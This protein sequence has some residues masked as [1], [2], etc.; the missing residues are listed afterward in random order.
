MNKSKAS[1]RGLVL[2]AALTLAGSL[3]LPLAAAARTPQV[4]VDPFYL[5]LLQDGEQY[6]RA[7]RFG[8]AAK[9]L[10]V[11]TFG[12]AQ[13]PKLL[14]KTLGYLSLAY[15][16]LKDDAKAKES[17]VRLIDLVGLS[18]MD[19]LGLDEQDRTYLSQIAAF[20]KLDRPAGQAPVPRTETLTGARPG[21]PGAAQGKAPAKSP[22]TMS[23]IQELEAQV[24]ARPNNPQAYLDLYAYRLEQKD[25]KGARKAL[26]GLSDKVPA[27]PRGPFLLGKLYYGQKDFKAAA[28]SLERA[29]ALLKTS[30]GSDKDQAE[31]RCY[32]IL[33]YNGLKKRPQVEKAC[34][35]FLARFTRESV[36][37][38]GLSDRDKSLVQSLLDAVKPAG[39]AAS[40]AM[41]PSAPVPSPP[42][43]AAPSAA[44]YQKEIKTHPKDVSLYYGL[45]DLHRQKKD[46]PAAKQALESLI[47]ANPSEVKA[48]LE[49]GRLRYRDKEYGKAVSVLTRVFNPPLNIGLPEDAR[50]EAAFYLALSQFQ[51]KSRASAIETYSVN[52]QSL[53]AF[54]A[55]HPDLAEAESLA[56]QTLSREAETAGQVYVLGLQVDKSGPSLEVKIG[57]SGPA[58]Y[59]T[60]VVPKEH[61]VVIEIFHVAAV[62]APERTEVNSQGIKAVRCFLYQPDSARVVLEW[63]SQIPSHRIQRT[64]SGLSIVVEK[65][66]P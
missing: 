16:N 13:D 14:G 4:Q 32:L 19:S 47:K 48:Y 35:E 28:K 54:V 66:A 20:Y 46:W 7:Q 58:T 41:E 6:Y 52:R 38:T 9:A 25:V 53:Q 64:D 61:S 8:E 34:R 33:A 15:F 26:E 49:L 42:P 63:Q 44:A 1:F 23:R 24:K 45:Y 27:D 36:S 21:A 51:D 50:A 2:A 55:D 43:P 62:E 12:L 29:V 60:F 57:L 56:W 18:G 30:S 40:P 11:A 10:D 5:K 17:L 39:S 65:T 59:R 3:A 31:A 37:A 22:G